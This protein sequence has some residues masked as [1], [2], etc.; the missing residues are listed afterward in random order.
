MNAA[1]L[2]SAAAAVLVPALAAAGTVTKT[3]PF[4][5]DAWIELGAQDGPVTLHR[6]RVASQAG[7][8][9]K[10]MVFRPGNSEFLATVQLQLEYTNT[11]KR[12]WQAALE[13]TW[14]DDAGAAID[15]YNG[16]EGLDGEEE[17][18]KTTV[19]LSTLKY[20]LERARKLKV[21]IEFD[22]D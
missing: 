8:F 4:K 11:E 5:L 15:G 10:S 13:V 22:P 21:R 6:I 12:D 20:G 1:S 16:E 19:T 3:V 17:R 7:P 2:V 18:D 14:V 9:T